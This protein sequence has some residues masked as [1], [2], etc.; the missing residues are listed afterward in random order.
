MVS[1][2]RG[3]DAKWEQKK[4]VWINRPETE[5]PVFKKLAREHVP[6]VLFLTQAF[7]IRQLEGGC[8]GPRKKT[9]SELAYE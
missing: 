8:A 7:Y 4:L 6:S 9:S 5:P 1:V 3:L 2:L